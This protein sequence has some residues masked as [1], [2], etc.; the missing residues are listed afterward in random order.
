M[1]RVRVPGDI[2]E[3]ATGFSGREWVLNDVAGWLKDGPE[4]FL[5]VTGAPGCGKS[6]VAVWLAG[7]GAAPEAVRADLESVRNAWSAAHFCVAEDRRGS[8]DPI[9]FV[10]SIADQLSA[11]FDAFAT[12]AIPSLG[13][14]INVHQYARENRGKIVGVYIN[15]LDLDGVN[16]TGVFNRALRDPL[17]EWWKQ[18]PQLRICILVDALDEA[19]TFGHPNIVSLLAGANDFPRGVRF[20]L[21]SR[22][23][24][25]VTEQ[26][27]AALKSG[28]ARRLDLS[29]TG[30]AQ[31]NDDDIHGYVEQRAKE[32]AIEAQL[33]ATGARAKAV[34]DLVTQAAGNFLYIKFLLDEVGKGRP[35]AELSGLPK[36]LY[37]LYRSYL[38][39]LMPE[40]LAAGTSSA[41]DT[42]FRPL[43]GDLSV[44]IPAAPLKTLPG[45]LNASSGTVNARLHKVSQVVEHGA[46]WGESY[47][48]YH[49]SMSEFLGAASYEENGAV[50]LNRYHA[51]PQEHH[52]LIA[53][54]YLN[55]FGGHWSECDAYG[56][57]QLVS[58]VHAALVLEALPKKRQARRERLYAIVFDDSF[59]RAQRDTLGSLDATLD[60]S[61]LALSVALAENEFP[62]AL[63]CAAICRDTIRSESFTK[64]V[65]EALDAGQLKTALQ[66]S[67]IFG[68]SPHWASA[69]KHYL[70]WEAAWSGDEGAVR[71]ALSD[72]P[73]MA[74]NTSPLCDALLVESARALTGKNR[75]PAAVLSTLHPRGED[76]AGLLAEY[77]Q[78][79]PDPPAKAQL[80]GALD[81]QLDYQEQQIAGGDP[82]WVSQ[83]NFANPAAVANG[84]VELRRLLVALAGEQAGRDSIDRALRPTLV[85]PYARYRDIALVNL[86]VAAAAVPDRTWASERLRKI[87]RTG[88][89]EEG[90][91]FTF[92][93]AFV[94]HEEGQ[95]RNLGSG[96]LRTLT[97]YLKHAVESQDRW[98]TATRARSARA[99]ALF[100]QGRAA[101]A[102]DE[103]KA[104]EAL[105]IGFAGY[106]AMTL[107]SLANR[108]LEFGDPVRAR[109]VARKAKER[110]GRVLD[111]EFRDER[112]RLV[113]AYETWMNEP[114]PVADAIATGIAAIQDPDVRMAYVEYLSARLAAPGADDVKGL[115]GLISPTLA[116][117]TALD[118]VLGRLFGL[119]ARRLDD[120][121]LAAVIRTCANLLATSR[122]WE[123]GI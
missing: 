20:L 111:A 82:E 106:A 73:W 91:T 67:D 53:D 120:D 95:R 88:L 117:G 90:V 121:G 44:A 41:W 27:A 25:K 35:L 16:A 70:A 26:F 109:D 30:L 72:T 112:L 110:A 59:R 84:S 34:R 123:L 43:L 68:V 52:D 18:N 3:R 94:L 83:R 9:C 7:V 105:D 99:A 58:H 24:P 23:E 31:K 13:T 116:D 113:A 103:L 28:S 93:L 33:Q 92:D 100:R 56:L 39:R 21:T 122:P 51:P 86:G 75:D 11:R 74:P 32:E 66:R 45:W 81:Q 5:L 76:A 107:L 89:D 1:E 57:K 97:D 115:E 108:W 80:L 63:A 119:A 4:R 40:M 38:D 104:S 17:N 49:R 98:G 102:V 101:E 60:D 46:D 14:T 64:G 77:P 47:R 12:H 54:Y 114:L 96:G 19:L 2:A 61:E 37:A 8:L 71:E 69:L 6:T 50:T 48:L 10:R 62:R 79:H 15:Q 22:N 36:E 118:A 85:N 78:G 55:N 87:L 29:S 65:F 42:D